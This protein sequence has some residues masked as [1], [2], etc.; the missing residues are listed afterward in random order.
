M[1]KEL[2]TSTC[3]VISYMGLGVIFFII[4]TFPVEFIHLVWRFIHG[5][6]NERFTTG[7]INLVLLGYILIVL[8]LLYSA[9]IYTACIFFNRVWVHVNN[10]EVVCEQKKELVNEYYDFNDDGEI[11]FDS[12]NNT[13]IMPM[14][15]QYTTDGKCRWEDGEE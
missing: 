15:E 11:I 10:P 14:P 3:L 12:S 9:S 8:F 4:F 2:W 7:A 5:K 6:K 13:I 1:I